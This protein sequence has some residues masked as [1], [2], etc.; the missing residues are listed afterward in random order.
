LD[1]F[2]LLWGGGGNT[3]SFDIAYASAANNTWGQFEIE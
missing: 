3:E 2:L 1:F